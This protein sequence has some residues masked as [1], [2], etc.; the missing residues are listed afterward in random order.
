MD[1]S[2]IVGHLSELRR[3]IPK[4]LETG[5]PKTSAKAHWARGAHE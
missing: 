1:V 2:S 4:P 5:S 3:E